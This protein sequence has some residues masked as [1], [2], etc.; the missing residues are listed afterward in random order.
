MRGATASN[1]EVSH[2]AQA[3]EMRHID[4]ADWAEY[5]RREKWRNV[6]SFVAT[7]ALMTDHLRQ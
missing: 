5:M 2:I 4:D 3:L 7:E 1:A 6:G